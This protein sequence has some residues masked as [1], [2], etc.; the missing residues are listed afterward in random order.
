M[1]STRELIGSGLHICTSITE[2]LPDEASLRRAS[3]TGM[4]VVNRGWNLAWEREEWRR[5]ATLGREHVSIRLYTDEVQIGPRWVPGSR[6]RCPCCVEVRGR[7]VLAHPLVE[8]LAIPRLPSDAGSPLLPE[9]FEAVLAHLAEVPLAP[10]EM[11][12][13]AVGSIRRHRVARSVHCPVCCTPV[14]D[15]SLDPPAELVLHTH[16]LSPNDPSRAAQ[17]TALLDR[18]VLHRDFVDP[19]YGPVR[20]IMREDSAPFAMSMAVLPDSSALGH[21]RA[22][23]FP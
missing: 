11:Y 7:S 20:A 21:G 16:P 9:L 18:T 4:V 12:E 13:V 2:V 15:R 1:T 10:G 5:S 3:P 17:G 22:L 19:R 14:A 6:P 23:T 8:K